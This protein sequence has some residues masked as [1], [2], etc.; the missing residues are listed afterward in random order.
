MKYIRTETGVIRVIEEYEDKYVV[1][2]H[3][4]NLITVPKD[5]VIKATNDIEELCDEIVAFKR[6]ADGYDWSILNAK[7]YTC[8]FKHEMDECHADGY[9]VYGAIWTENGL[10]YVAKM[11]EKGEWELL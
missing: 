6:K 10:T 8:G 2:N 9:S 5:W 3:V 7:D 11:D 1:Y 4:G